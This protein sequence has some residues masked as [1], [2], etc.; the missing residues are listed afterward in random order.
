VSK[1]RKALKYSAAGAVTTIYTLAVQRIIAG[2]QTPKEQDPRKVVATAGVLLG[3]T[4]AATI[5]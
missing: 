3:L 4:W 2:R 5:L 1:A